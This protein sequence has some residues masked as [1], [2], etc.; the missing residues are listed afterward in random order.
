MQC[1]NACLLPAPC[2][3]SKAPVMVRFCDR[4]G[5]LTCSR[6]EPSARGIVEHILLHGGTRLTSPGMPLR[7][8]FACQLIGLQVQ[9]ESPQCPS[10]RR[11]AVLCQYHLCN[12]KAACR[13]DA[14]HVPAVTGRE[15]PEANNAANE[16]RSRAVDA[17]DELK[18]S[19]MAQVDTHKASLAPQTD[20]AAFLHQRWLS[21]PA[22][23]SRLLWR[24][25]LYHCSLDKL[26]R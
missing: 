19:G 20:F 26:Q 15:A 17:F 6:G 1:S 4:P 18:Q 7:I 9:A 5:T 16:P 14:K 8:A 21:K 24:Q 23:C 22:S 11:S 25:A 12:G 10:W 13:G 2:G 3:A